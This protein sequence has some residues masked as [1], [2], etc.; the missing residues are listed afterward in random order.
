MSSMRPLISASVAPCAAS[1]AAAW[2]TVPRCRSTSDRPAPAADSSS[3]R[4]P[5]RVNASTWDGD[6]RTCS[7]GPAMGPASDSSVSAYQ[8]DG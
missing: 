5:H 3:Q 2:I 6:S 4:R 7:P 8:C 1:T